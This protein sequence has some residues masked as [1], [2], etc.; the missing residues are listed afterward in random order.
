MTTYYDYTHQCWIVDGIVQR[1]G[2]PDAMPCG[3]YGRQHEGE[4]VEQSET[5]QP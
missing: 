4:R 2:H 5:K 3:C 1:C